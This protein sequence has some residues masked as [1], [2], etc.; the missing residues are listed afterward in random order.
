MLT[1]VVESPYADDTAA[2][3]ARNLRYLRACMAYCLAQD[4]APYASHG[5]Y[6]QP[7]VLNDK[8][9]EERK[10]GMKAGFAIGARLKERWFFID[11]GMTGGMVSGEAAAK[12]AG[13]PTRRISLP[14]WEKNPAREAM[15][16]RVFAA[17]CHRFVMKDGSGQAPARDVVGTWTDDDLLQVEEWLAIPAH[18]TSRIPRA[19][20]EFLRSQL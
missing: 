18:Y 2:G 5:L 1:V 7:G 10:K 8:I 14:D 20:V 6:T 13:Q 15:I 17:L 4:A 19:I 11:L 3:I 12:K 9:P 16:D